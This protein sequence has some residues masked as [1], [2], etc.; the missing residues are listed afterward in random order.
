[1]KQN[2]RTKPS[3][4]FLLLNMIEIDE[5]NEFLQQTNYFICC[6]PLLFSNKSSLKTNS[7][8]IKYQNYQVAKI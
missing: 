5:G 2:M 3:V 4:L 8:T 1:M 6:K 7:L